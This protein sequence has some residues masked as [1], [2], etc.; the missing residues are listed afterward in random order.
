M[1]KDIFGLTSD[2]LQKRIRLEKSRIDEMKKIFCNLLEEVRYTAEED[3]WHRI[4]IFSV[5][6]STFSVMSYA[7]R[8]AV[9]YYLRKHPNIISKLS[10]K[11]KKN[12]TLD[13]MKPYLF[14][15]VAAE[16]KEQLGTKAN[17]FRHLSS[18]KLSDIGEKNVNKSV[19]FFA[20][21]L[22][23]LEFFLGKKNKTW[24]E[25]STYNISAFSGVP[26]ENTRAALNSLL[27]MRFLVMAYVP[28]EG[29]KGRRRMNV[30]VTLTE[31]EYNRAVSGEGIDAVQ[32]LTD[33]D[34]ID[35]HFKFTVLKYFYDAVEEVQ[36][37]NN[38]KRIRVAESYFSDTVQN[39]QSESKNKKN[40]QV[41]QPQI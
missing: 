36:E 21:V 7:E 5:N 28:C 6:S 17:Y 2:G 26:I 16:E 14:K 12:N 8:S 3:G 10:D 25:I 32:I 4:V 30:R 23:I 11:E 41:S 27:K 13:S 15:W 29:R 22:S 34:S 18:D 9:L 38:N 24:I 40:I 1:D 19:D 20:D 33:K 37:E 35:E 31:D 39:I